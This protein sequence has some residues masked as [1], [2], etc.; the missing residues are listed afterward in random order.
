METD[1]VFTR[2]DGVP[3][4]PDVV[5]QTVNRI[6]KESGLRRIRF[7][8]LRHA[9]PTLWLKSGEPTYVVSR[10]LVQAPA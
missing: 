6:V 4:D 1:L 7:R 10:R 5:S 8:D 2:P 9:Q 3:L